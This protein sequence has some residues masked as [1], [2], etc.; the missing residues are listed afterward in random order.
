[1]K[2]SPSRNSKNLLICITSN[3]IKE[4]D[5]DILSC[6]RCQRNVH[7]RC[8]MLPAYQIQLFQMK[9]RQH[10]FVCINCV[11]VDAKILELV[12]VKKRPQPSLKMEKE[13]KD[14]TRELDACKALLKQ[15]DSNKALNDTSI[16]ELNQ[17][18]KNLD[19]NPALYT[20]EYVEQKF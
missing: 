19:S 2:S 10:K 8:S 14:L 4:E 18:K 11:N 17:L 15:Y 12:P 16:E 5:I 3:C 7:Y 9:T 6:D 20:L 1:M 13:I